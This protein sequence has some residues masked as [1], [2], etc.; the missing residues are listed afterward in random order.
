[1]TEELENTSPSDW[2]RS[3]AALVGDHLNSILDSILDSIPDDAQRSAAARP[4]F[5]MLV[6]WLLGLLEDEAQHSEAARN[7]KT[8]VA[9]QVPLLLARELEELRQM[10]RAYEG[11]Q[12]LLKKSDVHLDLKAPG[13][14]TVR[15]GARGQWPALRSVVVKAVLQEKVLPSLARPERIDRLQEELRSIGFDLPRDKLDEL[16]SNIERKRT[17]NTN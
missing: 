4:V 1:M 7:L 11:L 14:A 6:G 3:L 10:Y 16:V 12:E 8:A 9:M 5:I 2:G 15:T 17:K 13:F